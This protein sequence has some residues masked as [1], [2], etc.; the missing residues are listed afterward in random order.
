MKYL[1][2]KINM[3]LNVAPSW[4][5][6]YFNTCK[7]WHKNVFN[8]QK[9][10]SQ[11]FLEYPFLVSNVLS[12]FKTDFLL[13]LQPSTGKNEKQEKGFPKF[14][15]RRLFPNEVRTVISSNVSVGDIYNC[16]LF[17]P[18]PFLEYEACILQM[19]TS[20]LRCVFPT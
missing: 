17:D 14:L 6:K 1:F 9:S 8:F 20:S 18:G 2:R 11:G 12:L 5:E 3:P 19:T 15:K 10:H 16:S 7:K 4:T 13:T